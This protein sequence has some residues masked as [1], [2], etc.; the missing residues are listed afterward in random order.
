MRA[1]LCACVAVCCTRAA[2]APAACCTRLEPALRRAACTLPTGLSDVA[3]GALAN[4]AQLRVAD[5]L[6]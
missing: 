3:F 6:R 5:S 2:P 4:L 1:W